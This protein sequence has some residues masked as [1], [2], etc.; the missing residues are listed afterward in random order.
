[1]QLMTYGDQ[2][3]YRSAECPK[4]DS[5]LCIQR[6]NFQRNT[7]RENLPLADQL[8]VRVVRALHDPAGPNQLILDGAGEQAQRLELRDQRLICGYPPGLIAR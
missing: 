1:M 3:Q 6:I 8:G 7:L 2:G 4:S 5:C